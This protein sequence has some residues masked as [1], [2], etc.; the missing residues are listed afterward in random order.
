MN[1]SYIVSYQ[2]DNIFLSFG[3]RYYEKSSKDDLKDWNITLSVETEMSEIDYYSPGALCNS[4]FQEFSATKTNIPKLGK[5]IQNS[6]SFPF[7]DIHGWVES[8]QN[9]PKVR[10]IQRIKSH[11]MTKN[12][13]CFLWHFNPK[14]DS[15]FRG[16]CKGI[17]FL[18]DVDGSEVFPTFSKPF[19]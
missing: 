10:L 6:Q 18:K 3:F 19:T 14:W 11:E 4:Y 1:S 2:S 16:V 9:G 17:H 5:V 15:Y 7:T 13:K 8:K 12:N